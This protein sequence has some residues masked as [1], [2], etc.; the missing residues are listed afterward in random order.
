[1]SQSDNLDPVV[2]VM[3]NDFLG[4]INWT[5]VSKGYYVGKL[6]GAFVPFRTW[7]VLE[8]DNISAI[9]YGNIDEIVIVTR[10]SSGLPSDNILKQSSV[11][12]RVYHGY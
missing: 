6:L 10:N 4:T 5:R 7:A 9:I 3:H 1:M 8:S 2:Y 12:I 11:E